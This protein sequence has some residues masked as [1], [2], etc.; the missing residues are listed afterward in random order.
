LRMTFLCLPIRDVRVGCGRRKLELKIW[1]D[2]LIGKSPHKSDSRSQIP[3]TRR[4][5]RIIARDEQDRPYPPG[6]TPFSRP[7]EGSKIL[8]T[9]KQT[10]TQSKTGDDFA[11]DWWHIKIFLFSI[12]WTTSE[13]NTWS[14]KSWRS[15]PFSQSPHRSLLND[16]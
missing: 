1:T 4:K 9:E 14:K 3:R 5:R 2:L 15:F 10:K 6:A 12:G 11:F 8:R 13:R 7:V 16:S